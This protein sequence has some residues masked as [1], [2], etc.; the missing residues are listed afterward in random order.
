MKQLAALL[1]ALPPNVR[2]AVYAFLAVLALGVAAWQASD[3][4][5]LNAIGLFLGFLGFGT[6]GVNVPPPSGE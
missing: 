4:D 3:G 5:W 6:A 1:R 2:L